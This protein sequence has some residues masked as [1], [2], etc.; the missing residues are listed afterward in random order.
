MWILD[1]VARDGVDLWICNGGSVQI[2]HHNYAPPFYLHL[3]DPH[4][5]GE[6]LEALECEY[7]ATEVRFATI[8][9]KLDGYA[10]YGGRDVAE[11]VEQQTGFSARLYNVD[12]HRD[13]QFLAGNALFPCGYADE[14]RFSPDVVHALRQA[15]IA[16][17]GNP[18]RDCFLPEMS[19]TQERT[20]KI[21]GNP[22]EI[23]TDLFALVETC[24]P[25]VILMPDADLWMPRIVRMAREYGIRQTIS[26]TGKFRLMN[27]R[28]YWSYG[29][30]EHKEG[31]VIPEGRI[32]IDTSRSFVYREGGLNGLL[33]ASRLSGLSPNLAS[34]FTPG[35][36]ISSYE[37]Y[38]ALKRGIV[39]P[40]RKS[41]VENVRRFAELR[42]TDRGGMMF[43]PPPG[44]YEQVLEVD[45]TSMYPS[46]IVRDNLSPETIE[47]P[48]WNGF[49][50][51]VLAP[52]LDMRKKTKQMK[53]TDPGYAGIDSVLKWL[54]VVCFGYTGYKNAK[55][56]R[57]E[58]HEKIT[59]SSREILLRTKEIAESLGCT[60]LHGIV[61]CLWVQGGKADA[62]KD[63]VERETGLPTE[64]EMF[65]WIVFLPQKDRSGAYNRYY[66]RRA[67]GSITVRGIAA[68]RHDTPAYVRKMQEEMLT[69]MRRAAT[70][71]ELRTFAGP[72]HAV[73]CAAVER[74][75]DVP[76]HDL[77]IHRRISRLKY[78]HRCLEGAAI[79]LYQRS[80]IGV[81]PGMEIC[82]IVRDAKRYVV[83]PEWAPGSADISYYRELLSKAWMEIAFAFGNPELFP[84]S[85]GDFP[86]ICDQIA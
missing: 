38:E 18:A 4:R 16:V 75:P 81:A 45:F 26:R 68:R 62:L 69:M 1:S 57:I 67:D 78:T 74:L 79:E 83:H 65:D 50:P 53:K 80:G 15:E 51:S 7:Q 47:H 19:F 85:A 54:L 70:V 17:H 76:V 12:L 5:F 14:S 8:F 59:G 61:D 3:P 34:R 52:L 56:G 36:I 77:A 37:I 33:V 21:T 10:V 25:H 49:L 32:L 6:M 84:E 2:V 41:D 40:F 82:Y 29:K 71:Q 63:Q 13:Q 23:L 20:E 55:F 42:E 39:V 27:A 24:D 72:V 58:T 73:Y 66:G 64:V 9:G 46:I 35:T 30:V 43:Q 22:R 86:G 11:A 44:I 31:A 28:S 48:E 60:V